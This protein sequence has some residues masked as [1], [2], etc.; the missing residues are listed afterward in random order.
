MEKNKDLCMQ[1]F[2]QHL[3]EMVE[4]NK[5]S[6]AEAKSASFHPD[7]LERNLTIIGH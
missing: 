2:D 7:Q 4:S 5:I 3:V 6:L 1:T